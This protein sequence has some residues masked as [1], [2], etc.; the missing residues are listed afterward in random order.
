MGIRMALGARSS[1]VVLMMMRRLAIPVSLGLVAGATLSYWAAR[2]VD[3]FLYGL[4]AR[5]PLTFAAAAVFLVAVSAVAA[6]LPARRAAI[7][8]PARVLRDA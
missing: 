4:D 3:S 1:G 2:Y 5:D 8:D 7:V 6:W